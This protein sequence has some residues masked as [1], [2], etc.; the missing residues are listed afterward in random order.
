VRAGEMG[1]AEPNSV[2]RRDFLRMAIGS[3]GVRLSHFSSVTSDRA[4]GSCCSYMYFE[5]HLDNN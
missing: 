2:L 5:A 3:A 4:C 1:A